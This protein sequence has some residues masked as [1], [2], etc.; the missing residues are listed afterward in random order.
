MS[1]D[2]EHEAREA[3]KYIPGVGLDDLSDRSKEGLQYGLKHRLFTQ[4]QV[5]TAQREYKE[6]RKSKK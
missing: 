5:D 1:R 3:I 6:S 2:L 4:S